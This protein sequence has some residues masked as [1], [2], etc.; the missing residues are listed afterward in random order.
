MILFNDDLHSVF[1][2]MGFD[3]KLLCLR[4]GR[5]RNKK[6]QDDAEKLDRL[7]KTSDLFKNCP[8]N[9]SLPGISESNDSLANQK[10]A[11]Q[12]FIACR[13]NCA[14]EDQRIRD[15]V[16]RRYCNSPPESARIWPACA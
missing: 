16:N 6:R 1:Q 5:C 4:S 8:A 15:V 14:K 7:H 3:L 2:R 10:F 11:G 12:I 13:K 9:F